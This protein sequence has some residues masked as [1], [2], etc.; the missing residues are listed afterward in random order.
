MI[1]FDNDWLPAEKHWPAVVLFNAPGSYE[2]ETNLRERVAR[3][4]PV[5]MPSVHVWGRPTDHTWEGQQ[6]MRELH[7]PGGRV[8][9]H[10]AGHFFPKEQEYYD[11]IL[12]EL[13]EGSWISFF[14]GVEARWNVRFGFIR[15]ICFSIQIVRCSR[16]ALLFSITAKK[17]GFYFEKPTDKKAKPELPI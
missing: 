14:F 3:H 5:R 17:H 6:K 9:R 4:G 16:I 8:V 11:T 7:H 13:K 1:E 10:E 12:A 15:C 2:A